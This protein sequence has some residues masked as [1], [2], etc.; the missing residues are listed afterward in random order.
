MTRLI[1]LIIKLELILTL[2]KFSLLTAYVN[3]NADLAQTI[4]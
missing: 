3:K 2:Y 1:G 4:Y